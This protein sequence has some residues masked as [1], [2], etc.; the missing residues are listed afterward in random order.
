MKISSKQYA[1]TLFSLVD[2]KNNEEINNIIVKFIAFIKKMGDIKK[3]QDIVTQFSN[4]YNEKKGIIE[5]TVV[6]V[7]KLDKD[8]LEKTK[9]FINSKYNAKSVTIN[10][11]IDK[12]IKGGIMIRVEDEIIDGSVSGRLNK[13]KLSLKK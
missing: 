11:I 5:A 1:Q 12:S 6:S 8:E 3:M 7:R 13:L 9:S 2:N 10:N 4:I